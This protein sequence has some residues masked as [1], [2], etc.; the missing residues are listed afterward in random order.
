MMQ[1]DNESEVQ[2]SGKL[3]PDG[4]PTY[5]TWNGSNYA[6]PTTD[7]IEQWFL[8]GFCE[9]LTGLVV[10]HDGHGSDGSPSW[11]IALGLV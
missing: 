11:F 5:V 10:D 7:D 3:R 1:Y 6:T 4:L 8:N 9:S 2:W